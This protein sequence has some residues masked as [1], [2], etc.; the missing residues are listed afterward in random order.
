M[1]LALNVASTFVPASLE[2]VLA[3]STSFSL[4]LTQIINR[5]APLISDELAICSAIWSSS[6]NVKT[7]ELFTKETRYTFFQRTY[8][9]VTVVIEE[10]L[11]YVSNV[12]LPIALQTKIIFRTL[13]FTVVVL[14]LSGLFFLIIKLLLVPVFLA[15]HERLHHLS[16]KNRVSVIKDDLTMV[17][18]NNGTVP[19]I[20]KPAFK[21][22][23]HGRGLI[24]TYPMRPAHQRQQ[25][26]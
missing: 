26:L 24:I 3:L 7:D 18:V 21:M 16:K 9:N 17:M 22:K 12:Q 13:L 10:S 5:T 14:E 4:Q 20:S 6:F 19:T 8:T 23:P 15:I 11:F 1:L 25:P 2:H